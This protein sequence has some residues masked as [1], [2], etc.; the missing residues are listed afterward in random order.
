MD[1][2]VFVPEGYEV[3]ETDNLVISDTTTIKTH[4]AKGIAEKHAEQL[5]NARIGP[6]IRWVVEPTSKALRKEYGWLNRWAVVPY[7][8]V[9]RKI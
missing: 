4:L 5:N 7:Q 3:V 9:L 2:E 1:F 8:N 6:L